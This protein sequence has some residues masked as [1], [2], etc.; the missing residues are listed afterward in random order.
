[1]RRSLVGTVLIALSALGLVVT[2][3]AVRRD[4]EAL[5]AYREKRLRDLFTDS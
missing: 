2:A 5:F 1:M 3:D 4:L